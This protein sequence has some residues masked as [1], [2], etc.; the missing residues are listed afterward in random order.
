MF[1]AA[2]VEAAARSYDSEVAGA[3]RSGD[4]RTRWWTPEVKGS[5]K[6]KKETY[7]SCRAC[8]TPEAADSYRQTKRSVAQVVSEAFFIF[9]IFILS[10]LILLQFKIHLSFLNARF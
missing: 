2:I 4:P 1:H 5:V 6:L 9:F 8:G 3:S 7:R 10:N